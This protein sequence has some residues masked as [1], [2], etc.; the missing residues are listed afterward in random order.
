MGSFDLSKLN[1]SNPLRKTHLSVVLRAPAL[2]EGHPY[3]AHLGQLVNCL[4]PVVHGLGEEGGELLVVEDL[5]AAARG[6]LA[7]RGGVKAV[8]VIT[9]P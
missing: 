3:G 8:M 2:D 6:D 4:E 1:K 5:E 7:D 9:V